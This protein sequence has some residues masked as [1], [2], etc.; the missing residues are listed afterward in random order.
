MPERA[1][2]QPGLIL[3]WD[4][5]DVAGSKQ[6]WRLSPTILR[7]G[8]RTPTHS[9]LNIPVEDAVTHTLSFVMGLSTWLWGQQSLPDPL[10]QLLQQSMPGEG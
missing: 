6:Y 1:S 3:S 7:L 9:L 10:H 5:H 2:N 4:E 8:C